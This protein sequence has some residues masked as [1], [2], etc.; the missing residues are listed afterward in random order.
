MKYR[1]LYHQ[2]AAAELKLENYTVFWPSGARRA[3]WSNVRHSPPA[4]MI[5]ALAVSVNLRAA[6]FIAGTS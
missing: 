1:K 4:L 6:T 2:Q 5:R 3:S